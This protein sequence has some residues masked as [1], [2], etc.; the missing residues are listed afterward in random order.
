MYLVAN[1]ICFGAAPSLSLSKCR[2]HPLGIL[3][4]NCKINLSPES[5]GR[6][7]LWDSVS[8]RDS[9]PRAGLSHL[10]GNKLSV[11]SSQ[12]QRQRKRQIPPAG[13][14][15]CWGPCQPCL[16]MPRWG[17]LARSLKVAR[18]RLWTITCPAKTHKEMSVSDI[19]ITDLLTSL[20]YCLFL[21]DLS[22]IVFPLLVSL[23]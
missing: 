21:Y 17:T 22:P 9:R 7:L 3:F 2:L 16:S 14:S 10:L 18:V 15:A 8:L 11:P 1:T 23:C 6:K 4:S 20:N 5:E 13:F 19:S 12:I